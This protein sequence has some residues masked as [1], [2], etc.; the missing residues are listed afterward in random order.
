MSAKSI[1]MLKIT[2]TLLDKLQVYG[3]RITFL[4][5]DP[6]QGSS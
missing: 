4:D 6:A 5:G 2:E 3:Q 1:A